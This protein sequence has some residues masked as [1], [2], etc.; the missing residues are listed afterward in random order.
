MRNHGAM[1]RHPL[2]PL[3]TS[4][5]MSVVLGFAEI[6]GETTSLQYF[7]PRPILHRRSPLQVSLP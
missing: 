2:H 1:T 4:Q 5:A 3:Y 6:K 7:P